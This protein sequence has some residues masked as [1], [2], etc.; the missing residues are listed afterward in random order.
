MREKRECIGGHNLGAA[1]GVRKCV[2]KSIEFEMHI[3]LQ[4]P[5][6]SL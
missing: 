3:D 5:M 6:G 2:A 1:E 4:C